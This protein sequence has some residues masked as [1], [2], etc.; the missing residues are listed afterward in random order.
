METVLIE[1]SGQR[2]WNWKKVSS[3][4]I[5]WIFQSL[6]SIKIYQ[7]I[8]LSPLIFNSSALQEGALYPPLLQMKA[9]PEHCF[10][11]QNILFAFCWD[12]LP[13][14]SGK[15]LLSLFLLADGL[16]SFNKF[17]PE[18]AHVRQI[19]TIN[20][21]CWGFWYDDWQRSLISPDLKSHMSCCFD[22]SSMEP[23]KAI[24]QAQKSWHQ[25]VRLGSADQKWIKIL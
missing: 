10:K 25:T 12:P 20:L 6:R 18:L 19:T 11:L 5:Y 17:P 14:D 7:E 15:S 2:W 8:V 21:I 23:S 13:G 22:W 9:A 1:T 24:Q 16:L 3:I 4:I